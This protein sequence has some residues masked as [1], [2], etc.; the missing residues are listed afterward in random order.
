MEG[1]HPFRVEH[2]GPAADNCKSLGNILTNVEKI[3]F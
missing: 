1:Q 2:Y 3:Q